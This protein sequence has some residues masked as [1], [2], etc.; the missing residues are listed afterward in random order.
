[1]L[2]PRSRRD[3]L[4]GWTRVSSGSSTVVQGFPCSPVSWRENEYGFWEGREHLWNLVLFKIK[5]IG[6]RWYWL[7]K[8]TIKITKLK[9]KFCAYQRLQWRKALFCATRDR[10]GT[11]PLALTLDNPLEDDYSHP[12][13]LA[14][15]MW[16]PWFPGEEHFS[17]ASW[18]SL[19][20]KGSFASGRWN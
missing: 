16:R 6:F 1:M 18:K 7:Q 5:T 13:N 19:C 15:I 10:H 12:R 4:L 2:R 14:L 8:S 11:G 3:T 9:E 20:L 17:Q